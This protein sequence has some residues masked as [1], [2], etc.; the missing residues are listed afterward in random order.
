M[1]TRVGYYGGN[2]T[3]NGVVAE[4]GMEWGLGPFNDR[5][6]LWTTTGST[7]S[8]GDGGWNKML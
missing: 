2:F 4:N 3:L 1:S 7:D 8:D 5:Q 6:L